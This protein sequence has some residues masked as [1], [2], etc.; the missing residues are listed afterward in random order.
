MQQ[1]PNCKKSFILALYL[2]QEKSHLSMC[3]G[4]SS[5][6]SSVMEGPDSTY[7][8]SRTK[9]WNKPP[10]KKLWVKKDF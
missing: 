2:V 1:W 7:T 9:A 10:Q 3:N 6:H 8:Q 4:M 5:L